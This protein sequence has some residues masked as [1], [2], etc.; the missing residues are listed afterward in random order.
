[1][2]ACVSERVLISFHFVQCF[3]FEKLI[4]DNFGFELE[5]FRN[6]IASL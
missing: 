2:R 4:E 6:I 3:G 1:M 5:K